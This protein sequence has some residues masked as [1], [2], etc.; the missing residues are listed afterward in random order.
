MDKKLDLNSLPKTYDD[1][2]VGDKYEI[3]KEI[4]VGSYG[5]VVQ[6]KEAGTGRKLAIKRIG[7]IFDDL[8]DGKRIL[9]EVALLR[10]L[11]HE[12]IVNIIEILKPKSLKSFN[13]IFVVLE[14]AQS[15]LK[16]LFKSPFHLEMTHINTLA[17]G[18]L[19]GKLLN[20]FSRPQQLKNT[21]FVFLEFFY[22]LELDTNLFRFEV[23]PQCRCVT[24]RS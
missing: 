17:Y 6:V 20:Y 15:D 11:N 22:F 9:R 18:T 16:K 23:H 5:S 13:E 14:Y 4:G 1:W 8:I 3:I 2:S 19:V 12:N 24:Q 10:R 21:I 7:Q